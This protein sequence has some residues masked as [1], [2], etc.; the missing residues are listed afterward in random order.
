MLQHL[1]LS[2][3][4]GS[5]LYLV[6][7]ESVKGNVGICGRKNSVIVIKPV[8]FC[9]LQISGE[10]TCTCDATEGDPDNTCRLLI[11]LLF[12][13]PVRFWRLTWKLPTNYKN[14]SH[15]NNNAHLLMAPGSQASCCTCVISNQLTALQ[16]RRYFHL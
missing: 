4:M 9:V 5:S 2:Y 10:N 8:T 12:C 11:Q 1:P 7:L 15:A 13:S 14:Y 16:D 3:F 6:I